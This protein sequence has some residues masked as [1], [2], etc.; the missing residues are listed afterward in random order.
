MVFKLRG[1]WYF[2]VKTDTYLFDVKLEHF[3]HVGGDVGEKGIG[4]PVGAHMGNHDRPHCLRRQNLS[5]RNFVAF[6]KMT[7]STV[8]LQI[9]TKLCVSSKELCFHFACSTKTK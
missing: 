7:V 1:E 6:L 4:S 9:V 5:P 3:F 8:V 2:F